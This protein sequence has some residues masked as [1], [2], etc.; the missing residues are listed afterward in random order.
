MEF[1][2]KAKIPRVDYLALTE[3]VTDDGALKVQK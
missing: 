1:A 2:I 3:I